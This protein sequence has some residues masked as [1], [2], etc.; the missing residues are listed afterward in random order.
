[1]AQ[2]DWSWEDL[3]DGELHELVP[4][5]DFVADDKPGPNEPELPSG[6]VV[7]ARVAEGW[8]SLAIRL[9]TLARA[10]GQKTPFPAYQV[11][12][13]CFFLFYGKK[14]LPK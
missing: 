7:G 3:F 12:K 4:G 5:E 14:E 13:K 6:A 10:L 11:G 2:R 9:N 8:S 1:M